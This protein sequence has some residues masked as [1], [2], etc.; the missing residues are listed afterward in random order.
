MFPT[1]TAAQVARIATHGTV[2]PVAT[3]EVLIEAGDAVVPFFVVR[4]GAIEIVQSST[5][6]DALVATHGPGHFTGEAT[7]FSAAA[8]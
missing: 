1:L 8:R 2:R 4:S 5:L 3:G 6:G 7:S